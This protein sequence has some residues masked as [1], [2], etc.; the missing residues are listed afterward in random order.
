GATINYSE[1]CS[2]DTT[3]GD[4]NSGITTLKVCKDGFVENNYCVPT[5][6]M[7]FYIKIQADYFR[8]HFAEDS[9]NGMKISLG[10]G[11]KNYDA[12]L[13]PKFF[14][15]TDNLS[16]SATYHIGNSFDGEF[17][18][19]GSS[20]LIVDKNNQNSSITLVPNGFGGVFG[21]GSSANIVCLLLVYTFNFPVNYSFEADIYNKLIAD[22]SNTYSAL[23]FKM[24]FIL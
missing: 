13:S 9:L 19:V 17:Y 2:F 1:A 5:Q 6:E 14:Q 11:C 23:L 7:R 21:Q 15:S 16:F 4:N 3:K 18:K 10:L 20:P 8:E 12:N 22:T 24:D